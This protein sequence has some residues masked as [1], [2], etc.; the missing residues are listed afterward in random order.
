MRISSA[1]SFDGRAAGAMGS[2]LCFTSGLGLVDAN[3]NRGS[4][5]G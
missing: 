4:R 2:A 5:D 1:R 3:G